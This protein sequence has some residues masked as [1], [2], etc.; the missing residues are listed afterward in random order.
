MTASSLSGDD[1]VRA[2]HG[3]SPCTVF[4]PLFTAA[5]SP[6]PDPPAPFAR[7]YSPVNKNRLLYDYYF[8]CHPTINVQHNLQH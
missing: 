8:P 6:W 3:G 1:S 4:L 5:S 2:G 7:K